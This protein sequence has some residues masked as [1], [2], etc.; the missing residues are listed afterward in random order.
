M[1][2]FVIGKTGCKKL[3]FL[4]LFL[5]LILISYCFFDIGEILPNYSLWY[6]VG[7]KIKVNQKT[8]K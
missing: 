8:Q 5:I 1:R 7:D 6:W 4:I 2:K 3:K